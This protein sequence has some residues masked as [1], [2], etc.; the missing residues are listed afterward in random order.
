[1]R[2]PRRGD[3]RRSGC[4]RRLGRALTARGGRGQ[5]KIFMLA[6]KYL[7]A[8]GYRK[9]VHLMNPM[10]PPRPAIQ[11]APARH[12]ARGRPV[13]RQSGRVCSALL[14]AMETA[15]ASLPY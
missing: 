6:D 15:P 9:R 5:R 4:E 11:S 1:M 8:L 10:V 13:D 7:P 12:S 14:T 3:A 2:A